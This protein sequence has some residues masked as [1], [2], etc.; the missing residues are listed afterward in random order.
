[1]GNA[2]PSP[3]P[4][5]TSTLHS[6]LNSPLPPNSISTSPRRRVP[7]NPLIL[8]AGESRRPHNKQFSPTMSPTLS[9]I[10]QGI[11]LDTTNLAM[12]QRLPPYPF[13]QQQSQQQQA[14]PQSQQ[15][16]YQ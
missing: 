13:C 8:S 9:S 16:G 12:D 3:S 11:P 6:P 7:L 15:Q 1:M 4:L 14:Y 2:A 5:S 10:T